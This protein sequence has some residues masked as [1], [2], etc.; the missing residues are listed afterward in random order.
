M[1]RGNVLRRY[2]QT[3]AFARNVSVSYLMFLQFVHPLA[4]FTLENLPLVVYVIS[5]NPC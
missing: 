4:I 5:I 2:T 3:K 1:F